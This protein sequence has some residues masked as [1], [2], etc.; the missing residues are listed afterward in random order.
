[1]ELIDVI[2][3][4]WIDPRIISSQYRN[5]D[6]FPNIVLEDFI[7][8][9]V[10]KR[11]AEEFPDLAKSKNSVVKFENEKEI[12]LAGI[13]MSI[14]SPAAIHLNNYL[15][16]DLMLAWLNELTG[17]TEPLISD[18][19]L[20][21]GGYHEIKKGGLLKVHADFNKHPTLNL[22]RRLNL[23]IYLNEGWKEEWGGD[24]QLFDSNVEHKAKSIY[25]KFN[26]AVIF[27]TT[28]FT[29]HGHPDPLNCPDNR[30]RRSLAYYYYSTGRPDGEVA[31]TVHSTL[32]KARKGEKFD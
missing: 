6:P 26:T 16:S 27:N 18:P 15:Q 10:L 5:G 32:F 8:H 28:S 7:S 12:K 23:L 2:N 20:S 14:L 9:D 30:S 22:D 24:L 19:Y 4:K 25:P 31:K 21:G 29:Y 13:G 17:I 11:V 3:E 1:M